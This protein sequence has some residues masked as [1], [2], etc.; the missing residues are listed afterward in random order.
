M[1][2][3]SPSTAI[4]RAKLIMEFAMLK[5]SKHFNFLA[6]FCFLLSFLKIAPFSQLFRAPSSGWWVKCQEPPDTS[7]LSKWEE[8]ELLLWQNCTK[9]CRFWLFLVIF[10]HMQNL[11]TTFHIVFLWLGICR[12]WKVNKILKFGSFCIWVSKWR[13]QSTSQPPR[14]VKFSSS[15][16]SWIQTK[17]RK[18]EKQ[19]KR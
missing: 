14:K 2:S 12:T 9:M 5:P 17:R 15:N 6:L 1:L 10:D 13:T 11:I 7:L 8:S 3:S 16:L 19:W 4:G 18:N